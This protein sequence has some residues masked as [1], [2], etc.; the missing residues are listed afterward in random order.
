MQLALSQKGNL[1]DDRNPSWLPLGAVWGRVICLVVL[2]LGGRDATDGCE[3]P[4]Q[5]G[6]L[7]EPKL[8]EPR[9]VEPWWNPCSRPKKAPNAESLAK[10]WQFVDQKKTRLII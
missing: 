4:Q 6:T 1:K 2:P 10:R 7:V 8:V 5:G 3:R 9:L